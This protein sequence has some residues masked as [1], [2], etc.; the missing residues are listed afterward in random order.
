MHTQDEFGDV[1][2]HGLCVALPS[3]FTRTTRRHWVNRTN[4]VEDLPRIS[5]KERRHPIPSGK[6]SP[7]KVAG[8]QLSAMCQATGTGGV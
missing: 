8:R 7:A 5:S 3:Q 2:A 4:Y 1:Y 6:K